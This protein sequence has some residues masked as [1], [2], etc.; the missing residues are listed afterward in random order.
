MKP[1]WRKGE[2]FERTR[3]FR[4][5]GTPAQVFPLLCPV[6]EYDWLPGWACTMR[7]SESG[8][9][10]KDAVFTTNEA[11]HQEAVWTTVTYQPD[12]LIEYLIVNG[13][14]AVVRLSIS[15]EPAEGGSTELNWRMLFTPISRMGAR[16]IR[17]RF[18][19]EGFRRMLDARESELNAYLAPGA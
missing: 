16:A 3:T 7:Y 18:S 13:K 19:P 9:A 15:L 4:V 12:T 14:N 5:R 2:R 10:E 1:K 11:L 17:H 8:V 6:R